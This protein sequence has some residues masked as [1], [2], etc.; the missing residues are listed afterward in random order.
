MKRLGQQKYVRK[1]TILFDAA[2]RQEKKRNRR[3]MFYVFLFLFVSFV[4][5]AVCVTVFLNVKT[6]KVNGNERYTYDEIISLAPI[7]IGENIF[8]FDKDD[9]E[10]AIAHSLPYVGTVEIKRDLPSTVEINIIEETPCFAAELAGD[11]YILSSKLKV[12]ERLK[13]TK[14]DSTGLSKLSLNNVK[15]C[16]VGDSIEFV[17]NRTFDAVISLCENFAENGIFDKIRGVDVHSRFDIYIYY[18][19]RYKVYIGDTENIDIKI[20]FLVEIIEELEPGSKGTIDVSNPR[21]AH[22]ALS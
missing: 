19:D 16:V 9:V 14:T 2:R 13:D 11:T 8:A 12:L 3:S 6:I 7:T 22:V 21:E 17:N 4:F 15:T 1:N 20:R 10:S 18:E 5:L